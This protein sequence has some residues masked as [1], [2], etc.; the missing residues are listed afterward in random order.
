M[1]GEATD[2]SD[3]AMNKALSNAAKYFYF[4]TFWFGIGG[5][6]DGDYD[7]IE[8]GA[9]A[10]AP[11][12]APQQSAPRPA[13][14]QSQSRPAGGATAGGGATEPQQKKIWA[15]A[16]KTLNWDD[17]QMFL[18]IE[19]ATGKKLPDLAS[20]TKSDASK[21]IEYFQSAIDNGTAPEVEPQGFE[22][23]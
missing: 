12:P 2:T 21:V 15:M 11:R 13:P 16:H 17:V 7:H 19:V 5:M 6:D 4:Q 20:L 22:A 18:Q 10:S 8:A 3:K 9:P 14:Q 1:V 23:F